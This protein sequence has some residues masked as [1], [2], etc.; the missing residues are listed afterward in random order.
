MARATPATASQPAAVEWQSGLGTGALGG[1]L[2][3][4][5]V[6]AR[7]PELFPPQSARG[8]SRDE[9]GEQRWWMPM[10]L[11]RWVR[12]HRQAVLI[13]AAVALGLAWAATS[14]SQRRR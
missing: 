6:N 14:Y 1:S 9:A 11:I 13:G 4:G 7:N 10:A 5:G 2:G 3:G 8:D 12:E